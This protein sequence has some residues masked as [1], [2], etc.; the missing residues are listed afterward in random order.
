MK[1]NNFIVFH[2]CIYIYIPNKYVQYRCSATSNYCFVSSYV[3]ERACR[4]SLFSTHPT[5]R[6]TLIRPQSPH[7]GDYLRR[8]TIVAEL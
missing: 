2:I 1:T 7:I 6:Y 8:S 5:D 4:I 3:N